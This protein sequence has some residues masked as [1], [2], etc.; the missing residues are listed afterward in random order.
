MKIDERTINHIVTSLLGSI[1][2][3]AADCLGNNDQDN[4]YRVETLG[5][6][7]GVIRLADKLKEVL[8]Q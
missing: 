5:Q 2:A 1:T 3:E 6:M 7:A 8:K 4:L